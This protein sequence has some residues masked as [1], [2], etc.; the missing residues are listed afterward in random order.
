[1]TAPPSSGLPDSG[2]A[3]RR[4]TNEHADRVRS[5]ELLAEEWARR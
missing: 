2:N 5:Y 1:M 3:V 4:L